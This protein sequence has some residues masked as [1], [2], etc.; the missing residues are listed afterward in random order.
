MYIT[1]HDIACQFW[2]NLQTAHENE[3]CVKCFQIRSFFFGPYFSV[4]GLNTEMLRISPYSVQMRGNTVQNKLCIWT[5]FTQ[6]R[7]LSK[8]VRITFLCALFFK[9]TWSIIFKP[10]LQLELSNALHTTFKII[11]HSTYFNLIFYLQLNS[12]I[13]WSSYLNCWINK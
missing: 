8:D 1:I 2:H 11:T 6:W 13:M 3:H 12:T 7:H 5:L 9:F 4:F 10:F